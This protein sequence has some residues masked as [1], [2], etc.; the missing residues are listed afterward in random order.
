[1]AKNIYLPPEEF[2][3]EY[4]SCLINNAPSEKLISYFEKIAKHVFPYTFGNFVNTHDK[5]ACINFAVA[6]AWKKWNKFD[7][8]KSSN[9]FSF[10]TTMIINDMILHFNQLNNCKKQLISIDSLTINKD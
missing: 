7:K 2:K 6:E 3:Q 4:D 10:F 9:L 8:N 1:M 5:N